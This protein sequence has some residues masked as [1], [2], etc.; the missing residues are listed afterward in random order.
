MQPYST[1]RYIPV[2]TMM[3]LR[4]EL[5]TVTHGATTDVVTIPATT[6]LAL[7]AV[8]D[9]AILD[10]KAPPPETTCHAANV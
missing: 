3:R 10:E 7:I 5:M 1:I 2:E 6:A 9:K 8:L 4:V